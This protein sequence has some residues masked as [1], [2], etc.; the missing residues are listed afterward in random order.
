[1]FEERL[2]LQSQSLLV[3]PEVRA[4]SEKLSFPFLFDVSIR[5]QLGIA[6]I[7]ISDDCLNEPF[8]FFVNVE[9]ARTVRTR[10]IDHPLLYDCALYS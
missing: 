10:A 4:N 2:L 6:H 9:L 3:L 8:R 5:T 7:G 1:M